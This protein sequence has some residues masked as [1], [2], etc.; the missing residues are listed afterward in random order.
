MIKIDRKNTWVLKTAIIEN[1]W[2]ISFKN[3]ILDGP[4]YLTPLIEFISF[5]IL[6][7]FFNVPE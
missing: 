6:I 2:I 5:K 3:D 7:S 1:E 4:K